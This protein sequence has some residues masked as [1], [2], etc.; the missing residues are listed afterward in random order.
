ME[1]VCVTLIIE[2]REFASASKRTQ[3]TRVIHDRQI[4]VRQRGVQERPY[5]RN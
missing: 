3:K 2:L 1:K 5:A 4:T